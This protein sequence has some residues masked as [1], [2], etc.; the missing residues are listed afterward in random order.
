MGMFS[1]IGK[2]IMSKETLG[3]GIGLIAEP[4][5]DSQLNKFLPQQQ[6]GP[7]G[8]D[9]VAGLVIGAMVAKKSGIVG[10]IGKGIMA[11]KIARIAG[12]IISGTGL[13]QSANGQ[14]SDGW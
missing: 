8:I 2:R 4:I 5:I 10:G 13:L 7:I 1:G 3:M 9:D 12:N 11:A 6:F 14:S